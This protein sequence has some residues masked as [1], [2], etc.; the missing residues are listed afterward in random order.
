MNAGTSTR[1]PRRRSSSGCWPVPSFSGFGGVEAAVRALRASVPL[2]NDEPDRIELGLKSIGSDTEFVGGPTRASWAAPPTKADSNHYVGAIAAGDRRSQ[3]VRALA[4]RRNSGAATASW[5]LKAG[6]C[7]ATRSSASW[8]IPRNGTTRSGSVS[9]AASGSPTTSWSM[10]RKPYEF[11][12]LLFGCRR[13]GALR[14]DS[15]SS[16]SAPAMNTCCTGSPITS[17][18]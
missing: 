1:R 15:A 4:C 11:T 10:H 14:D 12:Q 2:M 16:A 8:P 3:V 18:A 7:C 13:L 17:G 5:R 6:C 9:C